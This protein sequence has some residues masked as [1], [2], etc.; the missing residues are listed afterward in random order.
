MAPVYIPPEKSQPLNPR[1]SG[2]V[3][4]MVHVTAPA[5]LPGGYTFEANLNGNPERVFTARVVSE[6]GS[7]CALLSSTSLYSCRFYRS[8]KVASRKVRCSSPHSKTHS[9]VLAWIFQLD[10]GKT[11]CVLAAEPAHARLATLTSCVRSFAPK[12]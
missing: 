8:L 4:V 5:D 7:L 12:F 6:Q 11:P 3:P 9:R 10:L 2:T 1:V